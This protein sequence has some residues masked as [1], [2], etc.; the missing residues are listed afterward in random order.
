[1]NY[2]SLEIA[3]R[4]VDPEVALPYWDS[5]LDQNMPD[6]R[7]S[8]LWTPEF[9]GESDSVGNVINGPYANW[10]TVQGRADILR[11]NGAKGTLFTN[12]EVD[13]ILR[14]VR[15]Y[16][17]WAAGGYRGYRMYLAARG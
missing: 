4:R 9:F 17:R 12:N 10:Q 13:T 14:A 11:H 6:A 3:L 2:F 8:I 16:R 15:Y 7:D 1:V 5:T